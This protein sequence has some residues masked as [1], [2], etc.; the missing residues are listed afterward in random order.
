MNLA[1]YSL[2]AYLYNT[3]MRWIYKAGYN[4]KWYYYKN[5]QS[6]YAVYGLMENSLMHEAVLSSNVIS[7]WI[8][9]SSEFRER[10]VTMCAAFTNEQKKKYGGKWVKCESEGGSCKLVEKLKKREKP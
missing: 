4:L 6:L 8:E 7:T 5:S 9:N 10:R 3:A 1:A 2:S